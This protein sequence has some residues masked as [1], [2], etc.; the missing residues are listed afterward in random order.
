MPKMVILNTSNEI[1]YAI[2]GLSSITGSIFIS[3]LIIMI[4]LI[5]IA[6][7]LRI[8]LEFVAVFL[9]PLCIGF[10]VISG[11]FLSILIVILIYAGIIIAKNFI[12]NN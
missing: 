4:L 1:G 3:L 5:A 10:V 7:M 12:F 11:E 6:F 8:P 2:I 9:L